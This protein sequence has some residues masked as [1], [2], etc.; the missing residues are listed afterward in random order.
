MTDEHWSLSGLEGHVRLPNQLFEPLGQ[1]TIE[2]WMKQTD[3]GRFSSPL[4]F[5]RNQHSIGF[6]NKESTRTFQFFYY[7]NPGEIQVIS[8]PDIIPINQWI[9]VAGA[10]GPNGMQL[11]LNGVLVATNPISAGLTPQ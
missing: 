5:G 10:F 6:N 3:L 1:G 2:F 9:H 4:W 8:I 11:F 7:P